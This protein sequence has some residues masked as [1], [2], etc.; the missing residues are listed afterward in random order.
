MA[1]AADRVAEGRVDVEID[2][3]GHGEISKVADSFRAVIAHLK[4]MSEV[5]GQFA[6]G[7]LNVDVVPKSDGDVLGH[8]FVDLR[9]QMQEA[10]GEQSRTRQL[11]SGMGELVGTLQHLE[12]GL[13]SMNDG[14]LTVVVDAQ[15]DPITPEV[16]GQSV[17]FVA[18]WYNEMIE[19]AQ[20]S[21][22]AYNAMREALR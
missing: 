10:L 11:Q 6:N 19:S 15:L 7:H 9:D 3:Y 22:G 1:E 16:E 12:H 4:N 17:G 20:A 18:D 21:L 5:V 8:A 14:D 13:Q 2:I